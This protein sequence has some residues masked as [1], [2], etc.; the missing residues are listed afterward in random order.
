MNIVVL[1][2]GIS[3]ERDVSIVTGTLV[4]KALRERE[5]RAI[6]M[7]VYFG[8]PF[9]NIDRKDTERIFPL[10][11]DVEKASDYIKS[12][13]K[14]LEKYKNERREFFGENVISICQA[15]DIVFMALH[16]AEGE[17]GKIQSAFDLFGISYTGTDHLGSAM[18]MNKN[19]TKKLWQY[20]K[21]PVPKGYT[22]KRGEQFVLPHDKGLGYP[23]VVKVCCGGSSVGVYMADNDEQYRQALQQGFQ[24]EEEIVVEEYIKGRE[25]SVGVIEK[26]VLPIIEICPKEGF[27]DYKNK[28]N[29]GMTDEICPAPISEDLTKK[30]QEY[31]AMAA[32]ALMLHTYSRIDFLMDEHNQMYCLEANTLP[33]MTPTSLMPQEA[34]NIGLSYGELCEKLIEVS[35][36]KY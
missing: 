16:G 11:Y 22:L 6:L 24:L 8:L 19:I 32:Q 33:G 18:A 23:C 4:C 29:A 7:D 15:A 1:A 9:Q 13:N 14:D 26:Q 21:V 2:G 28:Y 25:F 27:Y 30:M 31:A 34:Q 5:H 20:S 17:N 3:T 10:D 36:K 35:L 12:F